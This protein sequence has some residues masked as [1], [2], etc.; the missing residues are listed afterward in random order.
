[1]DQEIRKGIRYDDCDAEQGDPAD[2]S[3]IHRA[4]KALKKALPLKLRDAP[5]RKK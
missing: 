1:M 3:T 2:I 5:G 4:I